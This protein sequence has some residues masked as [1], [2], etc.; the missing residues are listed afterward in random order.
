MM[1][2]GRECVRQG[3]ADAPSYSG[4]FVRRSEPLGLVST[5]ED[6]F[7]W[8]SKRGF[9]LI[10]HSWRTCGEPMPG[11]PD[12]TNRAAGSCGAYSWSEDGVSWQSSPVP[13]YDA[14][15]QWENGS[16][17]EL[18]ARQRPQVSIVPVVV[19]RCSLI[20]L[21]IFI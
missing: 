4:N 19:L 11:T 13:F 1:K 5:S 7:F 16:T 12:R 9:H 10:T 21:L 20:F 17:T 14:K 18:K 3:I 2:T 8:H 15:V 6:A